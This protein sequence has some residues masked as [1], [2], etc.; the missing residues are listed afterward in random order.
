MKTMDLM[1]ILKYPNQFE[2]VDKCAVC[3]QRWFEMSFALVRENAALRAQNDRLIAD[4]A[5]QVE[6]GELP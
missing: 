6:R 2:E 1:D 5:R 3:T 4:L